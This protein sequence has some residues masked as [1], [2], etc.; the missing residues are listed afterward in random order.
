MAKSKIFPQP[1]YHGASHP[2]ALGT[3]TDVPDA[4][5]WTQLLEALHCCLWELDVAV[6]V[7]VWGCQSDWHNSEHVSM[8][9]M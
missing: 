2:P 5:R 1:C 6:E 3:D 7:F 4:V 8:T 9:C